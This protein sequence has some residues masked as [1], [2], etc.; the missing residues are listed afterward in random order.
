[1]KS[2]LIATWEK[3]NHHLNDTSQQK[4][5]VQAQEHLTANVFFC[6]EEIEPTSLS[7]FYCLA[8][9]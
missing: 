8:V 5:F 6:L 7:I 9:L 3:K 2:F 1:M 4:E